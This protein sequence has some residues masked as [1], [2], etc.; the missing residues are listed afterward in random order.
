MKIVK[1]NPNNLRE[2]VDAMAE[3]V[4]IIKMGGTI[5]YPTDTVY[6]LG[7]NATNHEAVSRLFRIK[8]RPKTK[9]V[10]VIARDMAMVKELAWFD[11]KVEE[12]LAKIWPAAVTVVL[13]KKYILPE[14]ITAGKVTVGIRIPDYKLVHYLMEVAGVPLVATSANISGQQPSHRIGEVLKQ[15]EKETLQ[16]D[17]V[18]DAGDL[19]GSEP[20]TVL[21]L[22]EGQPRIIRIGPVNKKKLLEILAV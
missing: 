9:P 14:I 4:R 5:I 6:G 8:K 15:F 2:S 19:P 13:K 10:P 20:S 1:I 17:L 11:E 16:P 7:C 12:A 3:A 18:M 22:S 21:D